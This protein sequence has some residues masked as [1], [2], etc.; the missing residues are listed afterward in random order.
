MSDGFVEFDNVF[1]PCVI[2]LFV[3]CTLF[4]NGFRFETDSE[5]REWAHAKDI[6][7]MIFDF[8]VSYENVIVFMGLLVNCFR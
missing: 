2:I 7:K 4:W 6:V 3:L 5:Y 8:K 1:N